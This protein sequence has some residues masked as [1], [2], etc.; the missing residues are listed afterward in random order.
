MLRLH[1]ENRYFAKQDDRKTLHSVHIYHLQDKVCSLSDQMQ[2]MLNAVRWY[3]NKGPVLPLPST[4]NS[5]HIIIVLGITNCQL[6]GTCMHHHRQQWE[7]CITSVMT[8]D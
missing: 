7:L 2:E 3:D 8:C 1:Q 6:G 4:T 5:F